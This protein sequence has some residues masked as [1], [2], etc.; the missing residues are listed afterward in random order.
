MRNL[1]SVIALGLAISMFTTSVASA[2]RWNRTWRGGV[3]QY[4]Q[5]M[6]QFNRSNR[7]SWNQ[8]YRSYPNYSYPNYYYPNYYGG[9]Y[10]GYYSYPRYYNGFSLNFGNG[11]IYY[12]Y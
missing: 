1:I 4:N 12:S 6:R 10:G 9:Y 2:D 11:G 5:N 7:Q 8:G 3:R